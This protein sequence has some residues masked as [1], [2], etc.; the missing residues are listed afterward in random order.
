[1]LQRTLSIF[2]VAI[3]APIFAVPIGNQAGD[4]DDDTWGSEIFNGKQ[5]K[6]NSWPWMVQL[7]RNGR[8]TCGG[9]LIKRKWVVTAA[10]CVTR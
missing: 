10:H 3:F 4:G 2:A 6:P 9:T 8:F 7:L 1:M 5:A